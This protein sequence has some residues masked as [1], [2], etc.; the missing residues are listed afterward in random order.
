MP[1]SAIHS[2]KRVRS[3][4]S[5]LNRRRTG[6]RSARSSTCDAVRRCPARSISSANDSEHRVGLAKRAV[7]ES[8]S[9]VGPRARAGG[10]DVFGRLAGAERRLDQRRERLDVGAHDDHVARF[11]RRILL[12]QM[13]DHVAQ[14]LDLARTAV[15]RMDLD[16][17]VG[18]VEQP[19]DRPLVR[20]CGT[21]AGADPSLTAAWIS[22]SNVPGGVRRGWWWSHVSS[23]AARTS[24]ISRASRPHEASSGFAGSAAVMSSARRTIRGLPAVA[25]AT[26]SQSPGEG[27]SRKRCTSRCSASARRTSQVG[28]RQPGQAEERERV[29][30]PGELRIGAQP[31]A[32]RLEQ[33]G[34]RGSADLRR[35]AV[36][37]AP[38]ARP[39]PTAA[40]AQL[41]DVLSA[42]PR[43]AASRVGAARSG[44]TARRG[45][46][47]C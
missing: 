5:N 36:A 44:R 46:G 40:R 42:R 39:S 11:E 22:A 35:A 2:C 15:A 41:V 10:G 45:G 1:L 23:R 3:S 32:G 38:A 27:W 28:G 8:Y 18:G 47:R 30:K 9:Q 16:A 25:A 12:E 4:S 43:R 17:A 26:R 31:V 37:R 20:G 19:D 7:G 14:H 24:C 33:L 6:T 21:P 13:Q 34:G 29:G